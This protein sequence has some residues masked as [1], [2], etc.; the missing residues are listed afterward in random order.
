ME[1]IIVSLRRTHKEPSLRRERVVTALPEGHRE[2]VFRSPDRTPRLRATDDTLFGNVG[3]WCYGKITIPE[4]DVGPGENDV[5]GMNGTLGPKPV[6]GLLDL[7]GGLVGCFGLHFPITRGSLLS[8]M[9]L[10]LRLFVGWVIA[11]F[12][13]IIMGFVCCRVKELQRTVARPN[14]RLIPLVTSE[15]NED[16]TRRH[17]RCC[18]YR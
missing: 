12:S 11:F 6:D 2:N 10:L 7:L 1:K 18:N 13:C 5:W 15:A 3:G 17:E 16:L 9:R 14:I 4:L 8:T